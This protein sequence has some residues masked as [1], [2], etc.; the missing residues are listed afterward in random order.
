MNRPEIAAMLIEQ[1]AN[2]NA[3]TTVG[4]TALHHAALRE[5]TDFAELL[6]KNGAELSISDQSDCTPMDWAILKRSFVG[7]IDDAVAKGS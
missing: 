1:G 4:Q 3:L 7:T 5:N 2:V 6:L